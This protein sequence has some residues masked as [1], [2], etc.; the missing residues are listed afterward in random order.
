MFYNSKRFSIER[1]FKFSWPCRFRSTSAKKLEGKVRFGMSCAYFYP[2]E[3]HYYKQYRW[4]ILVG[5]KFNKWYQTRN[6]LAIGWRY[7]PDNDRIQ[8][9][10]IEIIGQSVYTGADEIE[11]KRNTIFPLSLSYSEDTGILILRNN[12]KTLYNQVCRNLYNFDKKVKIVQPTFEANWGSP[13]RMVIW[14][15]IIPKD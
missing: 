15:S 2:E 6:I 9:T 12:E 8:L 4:N 10:P 11:F 3:H 7:C 14:S 1:F 13:H 5:W